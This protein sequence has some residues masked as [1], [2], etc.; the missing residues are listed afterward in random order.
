MLEIRDT[1][2]GKPTAI[3]RGGYLHSS[4]DPRREARRFAEEALGGE[5]PSHILLLGEGLG[6]V[7]EALAELRPRARIIV[8]FFAA[9]LHRLRQGRPPAELCWHPERPVSLIS[10]LRAQL[11]ELEAEGLKI[12]EW[13][14]GARLFPE[15][16]RQARLAVR[17]LL[18]E[19]RG[20]LVTTA[21]LGRRW[22]RNSFLNFV[23]I[24]QVGSLSAEGLEAPVLIAASGP[25]LQEALPAIRSVRGRL[26]LWALPS[27]LGCLAAGG[28]EPDLTVIT[29]PGFW[30]FNHLAVAAARPRRLAMPLSAAA[31]SWRLPARVFYFSQEA[32]FER[33]LLEPSGLAVP[34]VPSQG[35]V[36]ASAMELALQL[37]ARE[38]VFAGLDFCYRDILSHGRPNAFEE[39]LRAGEHRLSPLHHRLF[40]RACQRA[41]RRD[42]I[43]TELALRTYAG[44]FAELPRRPRARLFRL[45]PSPVRLPDLWP[46]TGTELCRRFAGGACPGGEAAIFRAPAT[47]PDRPRRLAIARQLLDRWRAGLADTRTALARQ[48]EPEPLLGEGRLLPLLY[49]LD[50]AALAELRRLSRL[51]RRAEAAQRAREL[52]AGGLGWLD[53]LSDTLREAP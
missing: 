24:D 8:V 2:S 23:C 53:R 12:L 49:Y 28:L 3:L 48:P 40:A 6:Y 46:L 1:P 14:P 37:G 29:D 9:E 27:A 52:L 32:A 16:L 33:S 21:A 50:A 38:V 35:T 15:P 11:H 13:P 47:Y 36:A 10:F 26:Q 17:Q 42:G 5:S 43:R 25:S 7:S 22:L 39:H 51:G 4:R 31:G 41:P 34:A 19:L 45:H 30:A 18:A 44:W 20:S